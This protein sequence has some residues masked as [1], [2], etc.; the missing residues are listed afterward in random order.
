M[1]ILG[2]GFFPAALASTITVNTTRD[3]L[4]ADGDCSLREAVRSA[5]TN[6]AIDGCTAGSGADTINLP[7]GTYSLTLTGADDFNATTGDLDVTGDLTVSGA[8]RET[9]I[10]DGSALNDR[11]FYLIENGFLS[12]SLSDLTLS[13]GTAAGRAS[14]SGGLIWND[15]S[16][17]LVLTNCILTS[18]SAENGGCL[19]NKGPL[20]I[21]GSTFSGCQGT[22][23]G[24]ILNEGGTVTIASSTFTG[25]E[26][27]RAGVESGGGCILNLESSGGP[28]GDLAVT[29]SLFSDNSAGYGGCIASGAFR[30]GVSGPGSVTISQS[31]FSGNQAFVVGGA[32]YFSDPGGTMTVE[33]TTF[34]RNTVSGDGSGGALANGGGTAVIA[35]STFTENGAG[36]AGGAIAYFDT[37]TVT[38][39]TL[40]GNTATHGGG[41]AFSEP[42]EAPRGTEGSLTIRGTILAGNNTATGS[43]PDCTRLTSGGYNLIGDTTDCE[44]IPLETDLVDAYAGLGN[45]VENAEIPGGGYFPLLADSPAINAGDPTACAED[46]LATDQVGGGRVGSCDIGAIES[47]FSYP[48]RMMGEA[49]FGCSLNRYP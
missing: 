41:I 37:T 27:T 34:Y 46:A 23:G 16:N 31:T 30:G 20:A 48:P 9:T 35:N 19:L 42:E 45:Y 39:S 29:D 2:S 25:N 10:I 47:S 7:A 8:G 24:A 12:V 5:N 17:S 15:T 3:E 13:N 40:S 11:I 28:V 14:N 22:S 32:V 49:I 43:D 4:N 36:N 33:K 18:G 21:T 44:V 38:G 6:A 1:V 26:A